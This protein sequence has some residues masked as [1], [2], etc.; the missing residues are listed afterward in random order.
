MWM[1][2]KSKVWRVYILIVF[3]AAMIVL[4][5]RIS[6]VLPQLG[7]TVT[8]TVWYSGESGPWKAELMVPQAA[9]GSLS[10]F[11]T[12]DSSAL[13]A[14]EE[15]TVS[16]DVGYRADSREL[17]RSGEEPPF[18]QEQLDGLFYFGVNNAESRFPQ[19]PTVTVTVDGER[20]TLSLTEGKLDG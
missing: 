3:I 6:G 8:Q 18:T 5:I 7:G 12:G 9:V 17:R 4:G 20:W 2:G 19:D 14:A 10:L 15:I 11:Y 1:G 13:L 16:Y